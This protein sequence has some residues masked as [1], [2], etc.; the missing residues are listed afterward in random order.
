M[1]AYFTIEVHQ[2]INITVVSESVC[3]YGPEHPQFIDIMGFTQ[4]HQFVKIHFYEFHDKTV[5]TTSTLFRGSIEHRKEGVF[6]NDGDAE[7][8]GFLALGRPHVLPGEEI[9]GLL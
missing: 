1:V 3:Q 7:G 6:V 8:G 5:F 9:V 4:C 2:Q